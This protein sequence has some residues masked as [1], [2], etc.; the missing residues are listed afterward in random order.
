M[1]LGDGLLQ[2]VLNPPLACQVM[3]SCCGVI[4]SCPEDFQVVEQALYPPDGRESHL[5]LTLTK[6]NLNTEDAL[7]LLA[8]AI[9]VPRAEIGLAGLKDKFALTT[10]WITIPASAGEAL[11]DFQHECI[12]LS[13]PV[14]HGSKLRRG[15][16]KGNRFRI[17]VR[18]LSCTPAEA[19]ERVEARLGTLHSE[20]GLRNYYGPQRFGYGGAN[21]SRGLRLLSNPKRIRRGDLMLSAAQSAVFNLCLAQRVERGLMRSVLL[22]D[23]LRRR[24]SGGA[25]IC[26]DV[27]LDQQRFDAGELGL[28]AP[29]PGSKM[30]NPPE[31][32]PAAELEEAILSQLGTASSDWRSLGKKAQGSRR[33]LLLPLDAMELEFDR[34]AA[35]AELG[36]GL[37]CTFS[38]PAGAYATV[39]LA[40]LLGEFRVFDPRESTES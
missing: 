8:A 18:G 10:Q 2:Q 31:G 21:V 20:G 1:E 25:F 34:E 38:L 22:G 39:L 5:M 17:V 6:R 32:S 37:V 13:D 9:G 7:R 16:L 27:L 26:E 23:V 12:T 33:D 35:T 14:P 36:E 15:H 24:E 28:T 40:E 4:R 3:P 19:I 30:L 29:L 11:Q